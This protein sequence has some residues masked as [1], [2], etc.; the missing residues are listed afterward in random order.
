M[1]RKS[2]EAE[3]EASS[4]ADLNASSEWIDSGG[5][6]Y[7]RYRNRTVPRLMSRW[8]FSLVFRRA[9]FWEPETIKSGADQCEEANHKQYFY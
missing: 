1:I 4:P 9:P 6:D 8:H 7:L 5:L 3:Q 2:D